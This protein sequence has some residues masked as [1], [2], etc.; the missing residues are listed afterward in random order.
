MECG[1]TVPGIICGIDP[2]LVTTGYAVLKIE[3][4]ACAVLD[5]GVCR[6][7]DRD[8]LAVRLARVREDIGAILDEHRPSLLAVE[9]LYAHYK[10]P[11]TAILMG[12]ARGVILLAAAERDIPVRDYAA[13]Q[14]KRYLTGNGRATKRHVQNAVT[15]MLSLEAVPEPPDMADALA[16]ALCAAEDA[17]HPRPAEV[18]P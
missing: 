4:D 17:R 10:H 3:P 7:D 6:F 12:H 1:H 8:E 9:Q 5:A 11:R 14:V 15:R 16:I 13:T 18:L 2:G